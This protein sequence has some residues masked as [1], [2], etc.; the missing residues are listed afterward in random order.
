M[1]EL[2]LPETASPNRHDRLILASSSPRRR[3]LLRQ[4]GVN[5]DV[6]AQDIDETP[7]V[8]EVPVDYVCRLALTK[9]RAVLTGSGSVP[10][11][12]VLGADTIV[13]CAGQLLGKPRDRAHALNMLAR[14]SAGTHEVLSAVAMTDGIRESVLMSTTKVSF[15]ALSPLECEQYWLTGEPEGKAGAYAIQGL[16]AMFVTSING[17]YSGV[18]GLPLFET[19]E[20]LKQYGV[21]TGLQA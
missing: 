18:V 9:A 11:C 15:R 17:S 20:L 21:A 1:T 2:L 8:D 5:F 13:V 19:C 16:A 6:L 14:L 7:G 4:I 3:E 10:V 12:P